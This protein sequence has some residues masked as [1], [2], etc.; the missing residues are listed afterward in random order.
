MEV[1]EMTD[2]SNTSQLQTL[3]VVYTQQHSQWIVSD[4]GNE[5]QADQKSS[6]IHQRLLMDRQEC[7]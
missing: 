4:Q 6:Q 1:K 7:G 3:K 2:S 5:Q